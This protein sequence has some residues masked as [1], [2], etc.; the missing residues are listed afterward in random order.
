MINKLITK[1]SI[2]IYKSFFDKP[3]FYNKKKVSDNLKLLN[4]TLDSN[5]I[6]KN[7][8][9]EKIRNSLLLFF[10]IGVMMIILIISNL[11]AGILSEGKYIRRNS[12]GEGD[13]ELDINLKAEE[14]YDD[15]YSLTIKEKQYSYNEILEIFKEQE[16]EVETAF[17]N[18]NESLDC[19]NKPV[20]LVKNIYDGLIK[21]SWEF[22]VQGIFDTDGNI[23][24]DKVSKDGSIV[25]VK[26]I[27]KY[28]D[29]EYYYEFS[30]AVYE[31]VY[32]KEESFVRALENEINEKGRE[33]QTEDY[34]ELPTDVDGIKIVWKEPMDNSWLVLLFFGIIFIGA[35]FFIKDNELEKRVMERYRQMMMDYPEIIS[36]FSLMLS[37][38]MTIYMAW[39]RIV[40]DYLQKKQKGGQERYAYEEMLITLR[41]MQGGISELKAYDRFGKRCKVQSYLKF[42]T[43]IMQNLRMGS[44]G[45]LQLL[46]E[47]VE[48]SFMERKNSA[49]KM[50]E[51]AGTKLLFPMLMMLIVVLI[52]IMAP[53]F[54]NFNI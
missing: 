47:E 22:D 30:C 28:Y 20:S 5:E 18:D 38:G 21:V 51:E 40:E 1:L 35:L 23:V 29:Y 25:N 32:S 48:S 50:G 16:Q 26:A 6:T 27:M 2:K 19:I 42:S 13:L 31:P 10:I 12:Y 37:A 45:F 36:K 3:S 9:L 41:E 33:S 15:S 46:N 7:Y 53:A 14:I 34:F 52:I 8:Y 39:E 49:K 43:L 4:P 24:E 17:L 44:K 54:M 11:G